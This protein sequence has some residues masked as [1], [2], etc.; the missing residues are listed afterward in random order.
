MVCGHL[1]LTTK[2][3][4][5][6]YEPLLEKY[7]AEGCDFVVGDAPGADY[8]TQVFLKEKG[9]K[10]IVYHMFS[11]PRRYMNGHDLCGGYDSDK[12]R[13][14]AMIDIADKIVGWARPGREDSATYKYINLK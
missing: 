10:A 9:I 12:E 2:E 3:F 4:K 11:K 6:H 7:I 8:M 13:D 5:E 14:E 1:D